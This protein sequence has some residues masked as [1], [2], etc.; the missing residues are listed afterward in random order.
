MW[1]LEHWGTRE[2]AGFGAVGDAVAVQENIGKDNILKRGQQLAGYFRD[3]LAAAKWAE[4]L[5]PSHPAM[6]GSITSFRYANLDFETFNHKL[7]D[8]YR[9]TTPVFNEE[10]GV[11][12]R[13]STHIYNSFEQID[14]LVNILQTLQPKT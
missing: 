7:Y 14:L 12:Q 10:Q 8:G 13:V 3:Q 1:Q 4:L 2:M 11:V 6:T 5:T 9:I